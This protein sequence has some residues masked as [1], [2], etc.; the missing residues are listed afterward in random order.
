M[1]RVAKTLG[2]LIDLSGTLHVDKHA[3]PRAVEALKELRSSG[4]QVR[5]C[6]NTTKESVQR[7]LEKLRNIGFEINRE[8]VFTSLIAARNV[9][10]SMGVRPLLLLEPEALEDFSDISTEN[11]NAVVVGLSPSSFHYEKLNEAFRI[12]Q[13][14]NPLI[15]IHKARY[16]ARPDGLALG[17]GPFITA[18]E[19]VTDVKAQVVGKPEPSFFK[20]ALED[21]AIPAENAVMIGDDVR[22]DVAGAMDLGM[23]GF[24]VKTG[25]YRDGDEHDKGVT[26]SKVVTNFA[27]AVEVILQEREG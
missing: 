19:Y 3:T 16:F 7:L 6:T 10:R 4:V 11:P 26:P 17:P 1:A 18:L 27:E 8:E 13:S 14:G 12:I 24:L 21:M 25:K 5:F 9:V 2:V 20:L 23:R 15:A 22:D